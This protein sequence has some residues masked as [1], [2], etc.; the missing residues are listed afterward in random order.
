MLDSYNEENSI[1][2]LVYK[3]VMAL[4]GAACVRKWSQFYV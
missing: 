1:R 3:Y 2:K 4:F